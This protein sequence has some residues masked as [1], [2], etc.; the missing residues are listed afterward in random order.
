MKMPA[1]R[2]TKTLLL[3]TYYWPP[4]GGPGSLRPVKFAKYL[5]DFDI[6]PIILTRKDIA[7]H[8]YDR[9]LQGD[10]KNI[11]VLRTNSMDPARLL[12]IFGM[13]DYIVSRWHGP[14]KRTINFPDNKTLWVPFAYDAGRNTDF[15]CI[16]VTAPPFSSFI[17]A[18]YVARSTGKPLIVDFRDAWL[19]YPFMP[20][21]GFLQ[22]RF[23]QNWERKVVDMAKLIV[24]VDENIRSSL[25]K[26]Y[27]QTS[28]KICV[29]P[30]GYD[31]DDF[32][33]S[34]EPDK[35]TISYL[36]TIR[37]E[38][39]P[40]HV[41]EAVSR[42]IAENRI[43]EEEIRC[44][45]IGHV[46]EHFVQKMRD[47][48]FVELTGHLPYKKAISTFCNSHLAVL[49]STGSEYFF[50]SRQNEYLA[51]GL[52]II[53]CGRSK[54]LHILADALDQGYPGWT[55]AFDDVEGMARRF[56]HVYQKYRTGVI[57]RGQTPYHE[58]TR[59]NLTRVLAENIKKI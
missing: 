5:P 47:Y 35:F 25:L 15:D 34:K 29:I 12:R 36:G 7:Y 54:G 51:S 17:T 22:R 58:Y 21:K 38:R 45:F 52:P 48:S 53:V 3:I 16:L 23:V 2:G 31:P 30:N 59:K 26:R 28:R 40:E 46:E 56:N 42:F 10:V 41:L 39:N 18:Y 14:I 55:F 44:R 8:S 32:I 19:E 33:R 50:P 43:S 6:T 13:K 20:Y 24:V 9:E 49:I 57:I 1:G 11:K 4:L 27:P 37:A